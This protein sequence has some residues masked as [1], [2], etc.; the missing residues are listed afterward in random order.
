MKFFSMILSALIILPVNDMCFSAIGHKIRNELTVLRWFPLVLIAT[1][2]P[3]CQDGEEG[4]SDEVIPEVRPVNLYY[5]NS[6]GEVAITT[7]Y[8]DLSGTNYLAHWQLGDG[9]RSSINYYEHDSSG[10]Q[11]RKY[12]EFSDGFISDQH[13]FFDTEGR[14]IGENFSR[15]DSIEGKTDYEYDDQGRCMA[16]RCMGLNGWFHGD[17]IYF[18]DSEG[19]KT[20]AGIYQGGDSVG[21][22]EYSYDYFGNLVGEYWDF[23]GQWTQ[24]FTYEYQQ[25]A[26]KCFTS[27]N[28]F[29]R[30]NK[31]FRVNHE[32][33][34]YNDE[35]GE[36]SYYRYDDEGR[37]GEKEFIRSDGLSTR[38]TYQYDSTGILRS[39][40]RQYHNGDSANFHYWYSIDRK[41]LVRTFERSDG[42]SGSETYRYDENGL[43]ESGELNNFDGWLNGTLTLVYDGSGLLSAGKFLGNDGFDADLRFEYDLNMNLAAINWEFT[44]GGFQKYTY[45]YIG[46]D[47]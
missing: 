1:F 18:Y 6:T 28:V 36:P 43:L 9:S 41:L 37:L 12:R 13:F 46:C 26:A 34:I 38:T 2:L 4:S 5:E 23:N 30:E 29:I 24:T 20:G 19:M 16:A 47:L 17:L 8:Y 3:S 11:V 44:F 10:N 42:D 35:T 7:Y 21:F 15:S 45:T 25:G 39:S 40:F 27:S 32:E 22:I 31:W 33:Y 14:L